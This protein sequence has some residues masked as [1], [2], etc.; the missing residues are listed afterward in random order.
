MPKEQQTDLMRQM[1]GELI[2][3][4]V[5]IRQ[6]RR[7]VEQRWLDCYRAWMNISFDDRFRASLTSPNDYNVPAARRAV[8]RTVVRGVKLLTPNVK[9]F[10]MQPIDTWSEEKAENVDKFMWYVLRKRINSR[11]NISQLV[12]CMVM[13]GICHLK[14]SVTVQNGQV[15]PSQRAVDPFAFYTYPETAS[16]AD[17]A[18]LCFEDFLIGYD[19]YASMASRNI[20]GL[21]EINRHDLTAPDWPYHLTERLA[22]QG[23]TQPGQ[24]MSEARD[25]VGKELEATGSS[26]VSLTSMWLPKDD[27]LFQVYI[28]NNLKGGPC[29]KSFIQSEYDT[30]L[31]RT[32]VHR[33][34]PSELYTNSSLDDITELNTMHND[35]FNKFHEAVDRAAGFTAINA[36][37][38]TRADQLKVAPGALLKMHGDPRELISYISPPDVSAEILRAVQIELG[39]INSLG[40]NGTIA[41]G[42][43]GRNMP[44]AGGAVN[45][46]VNLA[47]A[48]IQDIAELIEQGALT[49][50]LSDIYKVSKQFIPDYQLM[51]IP[52]GKALYHGQESSILTQSDITGDY[53][54]EWVG[55]LQFQDEQQ[56]AQRMMVWLNLM[57]TLQPMLAQQGHMF[58]AVALIKLIWRY[59]LGQRG[60]SDVVIPIGQ[61]A[62]APIPEAAGQ[63]GSNG[64]QPPM[65]QGLAGLSPQLPK[66]TS[67]FIKN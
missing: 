9:W 24:D 27:K 10:E 37:M 62:Q 47:M 46:L 60:L 45:S 42:Q 26:F 15:W 12:R 44:R 31:Y 13:Y 23:I 53:E 19:K 3:R 67:G 57:P 7:W 61:P 56:N 50:S 51:R 63:P 29:I 39:L 25:K 21:E 59:S 30:P 55:S 38:M 2:D 22:H 66:A 64:T 49:P 20:M 5:G 36:D 17:E 32:V 1:S 58:N 16:T 43:P 41:E 28:V 4:T 18:E 35:D 33:A 65:G 11:S 34:L 14:T 6:R 54:F 8:E 48:D 40:G 52:G